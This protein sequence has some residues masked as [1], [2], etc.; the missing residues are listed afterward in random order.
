MIIQRKLDSFNFK[1]K[2]INWALLILI[3]Q[4]AFFEIKVE[5][6]KYKTRKKLE[7]EL[8]S[9]KAND[10]FL[11]Q[12]FDLLKKSYIYSVDKASFT[13]NQTHRNNKK[14]L[15]EKKY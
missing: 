1:N 9:R 7:I 13:Q 5:Y 2:I 8:E 12:Q 4:I 14:L 10:L 6:K 3:I 11:E 15:I